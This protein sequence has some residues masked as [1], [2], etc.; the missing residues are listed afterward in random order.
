VYRFVKERKF[1]PGC[2][3]SWARDSAQLK[4]RLRALVTS[5]APS[6]F[7]LGDRPTLADAAIYGNFYMLEWAMPGWVARELPQLAEWYALMER[8]GE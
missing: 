2:I 1:G 4:A 6:P 7:M 3:D 5:L 8:T